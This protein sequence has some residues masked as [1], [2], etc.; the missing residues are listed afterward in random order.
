MSDKFSSARHLFV[1]VAVCLLFSGYSWS[2]PPDGYRFLSYTDALNQAQQEGKPVFLYFGRYGCST[3]RRM[4]AEVFSDKKLR[5]RYNSNLVLA[6]VDTESGNRINLPDGERITEMQLAT[7]SRILGTPTFV[8][9]SADQ[10]PLIKTAGFKTVETMNQ[11]EAF[12]SGGHYRTS[13]FDK[14]I[15]PQ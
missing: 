9:F 15:Q 14:F 12:V 2:A 5:E 6:Y 1:A 13:T 8:Y 7:R 4:H 10:T 11:L 3:C